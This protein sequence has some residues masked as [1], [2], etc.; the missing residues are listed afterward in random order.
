[1]PKLPSW[2]DFITAFLLDI[3]S[4]IIRGVKRTG[5]MVGI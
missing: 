4:D 5:E 3:V 1:M 2:L